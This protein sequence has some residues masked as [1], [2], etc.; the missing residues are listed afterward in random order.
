MM[1]SSYLSD[2]Y[3]PQLLSYE[4]TAYII[5]N[6]D[7]FVPLLLKKS[8]AINFLIINTGVS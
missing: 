7:L 6:F 2:H 1:Q 3:D 4:I 8:N 5:T